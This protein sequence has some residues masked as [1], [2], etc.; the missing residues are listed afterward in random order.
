MPFDH[1]CC[2]ADKMII[3]VD[4]GGTFIDLVAVDLNGKTGIYKI[5]SYPHDQ[6]RGV[7]EG[8]KSLGI[9]PP[10]VERLVHGTTVGT[11][12]IVE[13]HGA[14]VAF[15]TTAGFLDIL[16][17]GRA[18]RMIPS[19]LF[20]P[21]FV[22]P[23][24]LVP[25]SL[26]FEI[27]ERTLHSGEVLGRPEEKG[28]MELC[29]QLRMAGA[30]AA[31]ICFLH[32]YANPENEEQVRN[33]ILKDFGPIPI[34][35]S[36]Q[37]VPEYR[38]FERYSTTVINAYI[39]PLME[40]YLRGLDKALT[41]DGYK[42]RILTVASS[43]GI[44]PLQAAIES[45][46]RTIRSGPAAGV[47]Q[48]VLVARQLNFQNIITYDMGGTSTDV[49]LVKSYSP[50]VSTDNL[51]DG[52]PLKIPQIEINSVGA[53]G[54]SIAWVDVDGGLKVGPHSA[55]AEPGPAAYGRGGRSPT[56][57]DAN[58]L[59]NRLN[60]RQILGG[61]IRLHL[62][63]AEEAFTE[64]ANRFPQLTV[65]EL[66]EGVIRLALI[67]MVGAIREISIQRGHDPREFVLIVFGGAGPMHATQVA[68]ELGIRKVLIP[69]LPG[70]FSALGLANCDLKYDY[71]KTKLSLLSKLTAEE[72][73]HEIHDL[74]QKA[75]K[76]LQDDGMEPHSMLFFPSLD[77]RYWGQA[78]E[79]HVAI[80]ET[81]LSI[82]HI[83]AGFNQ[84][85]HK[86]FGHSDP[87]AELELVNVRLSALGVVG[88]VQLS[89]LESPS[90]SLGDAEIE[91]RQVFFNGQFLRCPTYER[92]KIPFLRPFKGPAIIEEFGTTIV[93]FPEWQAEVDGYGNLIL[94]QP[95]G[96]KRGNQS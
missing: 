84:M 92:D 18:K 94:T 43:G 46:V 6:G 57:T 9:S 12:A 28:V 34:S 7:L 51:I 96:T 69:R 89:F 4:V 27:R 91:N 11:N 26:C 90:D 82:S 87:G 59:L 29:H 23:R 44:L 78:F 21:F 53:G 83:A 77:L 72:I 67:R 2:G 22:R 62:E 3:G 61:T 37:V 68:E 19:T 60:P 88:K 55:G 48:S 80:P 52:F 66:A 1:V 24:P 79:L 81:S 5:P 14:R 54:G 13:R 31:A 74:R 16:E 63:R 15:I 95:Q 36:S 40:S 47:V 45:P 20:K 30:E 41:E 10:A 86:T 35:I 71:V 75:Y 76:Q 42:K 70:N 64:I 33:F 38:E 17:I 85:H 56:V 25:R 65:H 58:L 49:C 8:L 50:S 73:A 32:S 39:Q 93:V